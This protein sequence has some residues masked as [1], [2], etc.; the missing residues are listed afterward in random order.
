MI[1][2][3]QNQMRQMQQAAGHIPSESAV[4]GFDDSTP[5]SERSLSFPPAHQ[6][7]GT[8]TNP[9]PR[10][11]AAQSHPRS[12]FDLSRQPSRRS[13]TPSR[14]ASP[15]LLPLSAGL[16]ASGEGADHAWPLGGG[17][18]ENAFYQ[19]ETHML[20]RENGML[21]MRIR[22]LGMFYK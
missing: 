1:R 7:S 10:S 2:Q 8:V 16:S 17:R 19:A 4:A 9:Q 13:R 21:R 3:Q 15:A 11:P 22:E 12:S 18:D 5:T 6:P 14:A 20:I